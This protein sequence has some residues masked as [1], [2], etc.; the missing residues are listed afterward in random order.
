[1]LVGISQVAMDAADMMT[2]YRAERSS[3]EEKKGGGG[4]TDYAQYICASGRCTRC[5]C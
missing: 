5:C 2:R 3:E 1:M 4:E